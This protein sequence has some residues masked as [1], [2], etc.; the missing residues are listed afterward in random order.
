MYLMFGDEADP[1]YTKNARFFLYGGVY[2]PSRRANRLDAAIRSIRRN[3]GFNTTDSLKFSAKDCPNELCKEDFAKAKEEVLQSALDNDVKFC[4]YV[5]LHE[6]AQAQEIHTRIRWGMN[7]I[8]GNYNKFL[9]N[10]DS[11][12]IVYLDRLS[13]PNIFNYFT[14]WNSKGLSLRN[15][16]YLYLDR[17]LSYGLTCDN[18]SSF[19]SVSDIV[20]GS[21]RHCVN[22]EQRDIVGKKLLPK[23]V[24]LMW[25][26]TQNNKLLIR[27][28]GLLLRPKAAVTN[29][30]YEA[31][32]A[33]LIAR[34]N[35]WLQEGKQE[36][37]QS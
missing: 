33:E 1:E 5:V 30:K 23:V 31:Q 2:I 24:K 9:R 10:K 14:E 18:A 37:D 13:D 34:L 20:L 26:N 36:V 25:T 11:H 3:Y 15:N 6:I 19:A 29:P 4:A 7:S 17:I 16:N 35:E 21:F 32:Y 12:G 27:E 22:E 8:I 28:F